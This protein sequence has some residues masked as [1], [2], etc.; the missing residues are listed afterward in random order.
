MTT[1]LITLVIA[2]DHP[3]FRAGLRQ[4]LTQEPGFG[5]LDEA[6]D[7]LAALAAIED[8]RPHVAVL[9]VDMPGLDGLEVARAVRDRRLE[10]A[11]IC[12]TM[13]R[14]AL[15]LEAALQAGVMGYVVKDDA[16]V[17][18]VDSIRTVAAGGHHVSR[19]LTTNLVTRHRRAVDLAQRRPEVDALTRSERQVLRLVAELKTTKEIAV[20][21]DISPRTVDRHRANM[22]E[23][24]GLNG[25][26][27]L[28]KFALEHRAAL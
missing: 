21:L 10:T 4:V 6:S 9:D 22:V 25:T 28:T 14:D 3:I 7:G 12:L 18:I 2:D 20:A 11:I 26:H 19:Q 23:K 8:L 5:V 17:E 15:Y 13:H 27:A 24:L 1:P 16:L